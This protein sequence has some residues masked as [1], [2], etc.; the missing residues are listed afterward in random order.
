MMFG[1]FF[2]VFF[3]THPNHTMV[4]SLFLSIL[5]F[6]C[7]SYC[8]SVVGFSVSPIIHKRLLKPTRTRHDLAIDEN[9][10]SRQPADKEHP[11]AQT[12]R[13]S[14]VML[15]VPSVDT[16]V[17]YWKNIQG[18]SIR[19]STEN[20]AMVEFG[21]HDEE[22][23]KDSCFALEFTTNTKKDFSIGN[24]ISYIGLSMLLAIKKNKN[25][26]EMMMRKEESNDDKNMEPNGI[27]V[28][29]SA[30][31]PGDYL[32]RLALMSNNNLDETQAFYTSI[33]GMDTKARDESMLCLRYDNER[34]S[35]V[36]TT[37]IF[38]NTSDEL[39]MGDCLDH[40]VI[41]TKMN[42]EEFYTSLDGEKVFM[43][44]TKMFGRDVMGLL[45]PNGYKIILAT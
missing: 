26:L 2:V 22:N 10:I 16:T 42:I 15:C 33:L 9:T 30:S 39:N 35:G 19:V 1:W 40:F 3:L 11:L 5:L 24:V 6:H 43:K 25:P 13:L 36:Q 20:S 44:P 34:F 37:L 7:L 41:D 32:A 28:Q 21:S 27:Q 45:D 4:S 23:P 38:I 29:S 17:E 18:G 14:H 12:S 31:A 8:P